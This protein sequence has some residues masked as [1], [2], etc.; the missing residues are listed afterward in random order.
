M[1]ASFSKV[2]IHKLRLEFTLNKPE[3]VIAGC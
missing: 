1:S 2:I 3:R